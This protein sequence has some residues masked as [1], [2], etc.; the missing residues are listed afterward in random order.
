MD[1]ICEALCR[2][3]ISACNGQYGVFYEDELMEAIPD[4]ENKTRETLEAAL[5]TLV[6]GGYIDVKYAR[7]SAFCLAG[8]RQYVAEQPVAEV[9][10]VQKGESAQEGDRARSF[11]SY[12]FYFAAAFAGS[13]VGGILG[14]LIASAF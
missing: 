7:G 14:G 1:E 2:K 5:K 12:I 3:I 10:T 11:K 4:E 9:E 13:F 8:I 6:N